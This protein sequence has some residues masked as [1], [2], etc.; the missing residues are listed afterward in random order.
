MHEITRKVQIDS[1]LEAVF[2]LLSDLD[3]RPDW[4]TTTVRTFDVPGGPLRSGQTFRQ[5]MR[6]VGRP[7][8]SEWRVVHVDR[9]CRLVFESVCTNGGTLS[10]TQ[11]LAAIGDT[12]T[13]EIVVRYALPLDLRWGPL[14]LN[15]IERRIQREV[16]VSL[17]NLRDLLE[18]GT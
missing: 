12:T 13:V 1:N 8:E 17:H 15:Y 9:P 18:Q 10:M 4:V 14:G 3:R 16:A 5:I 2:A 7:V 6:V 11:T